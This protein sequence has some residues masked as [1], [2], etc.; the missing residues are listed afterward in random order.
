MFSMW[1]F[2]V[3]LKSNLTVGN[4]RV[5]P[6]GLKNVACCSIGELPPTSLNT[7]FTPLRADLSEAN[8]AAIVASG[9]FGSPAAAAS[10]NTLT[11]QVK[12]PLPVHV[13]LGGGAPAYVALVVVNW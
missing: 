4:L 11:L 5:C 12:V 3:T 1:C 2:F 9:V 13:T 8:K 10:V 6:P 7:A